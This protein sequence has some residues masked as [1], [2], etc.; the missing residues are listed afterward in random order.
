[1]T[2]P[3]FF[4]AGLPSSGRHRSRRAS[5]ALAAIT[6]F[7]A[8]CASRPDPPPTPEP[9]STFRLGTVARAEV[10]TP[11]T[12]TAAVDRVITKS[13]F[14]VRDVDLTGGTLLV[15]SAEPITVEPPQLATVRGT[16]IDFSRRELSDRYQ[17]GYSEAYREFEG[18][19][20]LA[21]EE[22]TVW[23]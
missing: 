11:L 13:V 12:V 3:W 15:L 8:G 16:V 23:E 10:G 19:R 14:V 20:A 21:A 6:L 22:V 17:L 9:T 5:V 4:P 18:G 7:V 1:M 2:R